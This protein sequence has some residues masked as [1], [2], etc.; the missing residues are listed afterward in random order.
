MHDL[1]RASRHGDQEPAAEAGDLPLPAMPCRPRR[2]S[3]ANI[4]AGTTG[5]HC[6]SLPESTVHR[7]YSLPHPDPRLGPRVGHRSWILYAL[8]NQ[9]RLRAHRA[10]GGLHE[11]DFAGGTAHDLE[12]CAI[13]A[14]TEVRCILVCAGLSAARGDAAAD[15]AT[16]SQ[17]QTPPA[18][19]S[20]SPQLEPV[21][22]FLLTTRVY[23]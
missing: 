13:G 3:H 8:T 17:S 9:A 14:R 2:Q 5:I 1:P 7:L 16:N 11:R 21:Y 20:T 6:I 18:T 12:A 4:T 22:R 10:R 23:R 19:S 15:A